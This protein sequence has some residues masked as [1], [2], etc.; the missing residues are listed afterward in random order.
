MSEEGAPVL[1]SLEE[2][3][4]FD[5]AER[6]AAVHAEQEEWYFGPRTRQTVNFFGMPI[7][8]LLLAL[9]TNRWSMSCELS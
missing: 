1:R 8:D 3:F 9:P 6:S 4:R 5:V 2:A 7:G